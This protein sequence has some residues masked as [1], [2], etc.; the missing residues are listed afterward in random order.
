MRRPP[1]AR[2]LWDRLTVLYDL[3]GVPIP[4][5]RLS[6]PGHLGA[7]SRIGGLGCSVRGQR[8]TAKITL[9]LDSIIS[10]GL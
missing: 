5:E 9:A 10:L 2:A 1:A 7:G 4:R 8:M 6:K 3:Y